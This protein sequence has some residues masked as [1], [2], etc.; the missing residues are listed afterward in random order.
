MNPPFL[1][2]FAQRHAPEEPDWMRWIIIGLFFGFPLLVRIVR[3]VLVHFGLARPEPEEPARGER[4]RGRARRQEQRKVEDEGEELWRRL[5]RGDVAEAPPPAAPPPAREARPAPARPRAEPV[6]A[7][8]LEP[9]LPETSLEEGGAPQPL[10]VLGDVSEPGE[11]PE[12]SL[13][14]ELEPAPLAFLGDEDPLQRA[15]RGR[16]EEPAAGLTVRPRAAF[17]L[18]RGDLRRAIVLS[19]VLGPPLSQRP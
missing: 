16:A 17:R 10:S 4:A 13:E 3:A 2:L 9:A 7:S 14:R 1:L 8:V 11:A 12:V 18:A 19:E 5:A 15:S 6:P